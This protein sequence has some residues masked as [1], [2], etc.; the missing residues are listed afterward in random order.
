MTTAERQQTNY[1]RLQLIHRN[2]RPKVAAVLSDLEGH[3]TQPVIDAK[4]WRKPSEQLALYRQGFSRV[5]YS[6]HNC[7]SRKGTPESMAADIVE[8]RFLWDSPSW[9]WLKLAASAKAHGLESGIY[10][11]LTTFQRD[12]ISSAIIAQEWTTSPL[13]IGWDP[14][15]VQV[16]GISLLRAKLGARP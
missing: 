13:S 4:V 7:T 11:G 8:A 2:L 14:A 9:F 16:K 6:Y 10:W 15:H 3:N 5:K 1:K 12:Q